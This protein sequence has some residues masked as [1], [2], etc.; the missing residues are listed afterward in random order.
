MK[1][2]FLLPCLVLVGNSCLAYGGVTVFGVLDAS[3]THYRVAAGSAQGLHL[4]G[5]SQTVLANGANTA[6]R[7]GFKGVED[8]GGGLSAGFWLEAPLSNDNG[9]A[10]TRP[11]NF[12]RRATVSLLSSMGEL[13]LGRDNTPTDWNDVI[14]SPFGP[15]SVGSSM[16]LQVAGVNMS[17][18]SQL[19][20]DVN[21]VRA[22]NTLG[23]F[24][25]KNS[26]GIYGQAMYAFDE[27]ADNRKPT[28]P[29]DLVQL[30]RKKS[31]YMGARL[32]YK[33]GPLDVAASAGWSDLGDPVGARRISGNEF[34]HFGARVRTI[35]FGASYDWR[36][37]R[38]MGEWSDVRTSYWEASTTGR[39]LPS[40]D[41]T[42]SR[43]WVFGGVIPV[44]RNDVK[45]SYS[46]LHVRMPADLGIESPKFQKLTIGGIHNFS[47]RTAAYASLA[48]LKNSHGAALP[49]G[50]SGNS[51]VPIK[52]VPN[53][54][55][56]GFEMGLRHAF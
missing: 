35:N 8:L 50:G 9:S 3:V 14:F 1:Y 19:P 33:S 6:S 13:R 42:V 52:G 51:L 17:G 43:S 39:P 25:P 12:S 38:L 7:L 40:F 2:K 44:G 37:M 4:P 31:R 20:G 56:T 34:A 46:Q 18:R 21:A 36:W 41:T 27:T 47:K 24:L 55:A 48:Y 28:Y 45:F 29:E 54:N 23:Y 32:G 49:A 53:A 16:T 5:S 22:S 30:Q 26:L 15:Q 11:F 10:V